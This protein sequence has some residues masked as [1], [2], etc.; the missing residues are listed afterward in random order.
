MSENII[1]E[2]IQ[3]LKEMIKANNFIGEPIET[4][5]KLMIPFMKIGFGFCGANGEGKTN[6]AAGF[7]GGV[8]IEPVSM[9]VIN[10]DT[11]ISDG[12]KVLN[13]SEASENSRIISDLGLVITDLIKEILA[14]IQA[15]TSS[16]VD[17]GDIDNCE[18]PENPD[19][20]VAEENI[21]DD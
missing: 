10:K 2:S 11:G 1:K 9:V 16:S 5:D 17:Y 14:N 21:T 3:E 4:E 15:P 19:E 8:G 20:V 13:L 7:G 6:N 12:I 18:N